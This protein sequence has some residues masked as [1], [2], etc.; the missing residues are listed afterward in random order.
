MAALDRPV[1]LRIIAYA[2]K[3]S[4][5]KIEHYVII[6][7]DMTENYA[8]KRKLREQMHNIAVYTGSK[9]ARA[10]KLVEIEKEIADL[11]KQIR[12]LGAEPAG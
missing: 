6:I 1:T 11:E 4:T 5:Q 8:V 2:L 12:D 7:D 3:S 9:S 10:A